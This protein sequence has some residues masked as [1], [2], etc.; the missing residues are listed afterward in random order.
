M[1][2]DESPCLRCIH[3]MYDIDGEGRCTYGGACYEP[4]KL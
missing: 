3:Y 4:N 1:D 2:S